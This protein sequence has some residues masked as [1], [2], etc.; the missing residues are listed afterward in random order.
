MAKYL[1]VAK[2]YEKLKVKREQSKIKSNYISEILPYLHD[3][4]ALAQW[5][6][7]QVCAT[8][9]ALLYLILVVVLKNLTRKMQ[10]NILY[11]VKI[12]N[13]QKTNW[14]TKSK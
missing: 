13:I 6:Q 7:R 2:L 4:N 5:L 9:F 11:E 10:K 1:P 14:E 12:Y 8:Y 3:P